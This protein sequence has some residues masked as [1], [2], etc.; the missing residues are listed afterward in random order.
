[1]TKLLIIVF[2]VKRN[3]KLGQGISNSCVAAFSKSQ[4]VCCS[5]SKRDDELVFT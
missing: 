5:I 3:L 4:S 1:M 2:L